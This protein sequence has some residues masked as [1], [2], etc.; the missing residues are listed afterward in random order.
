MKF[1]TEYNLKI[2][3]EDCEP[4]LF[5]TKKERYSTPISNDTAILMLS[6]IDELEQQLKDVEKA[7][8]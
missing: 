4:D 2:F 1:E 8:S 6:L 5:S 3:R 7:I